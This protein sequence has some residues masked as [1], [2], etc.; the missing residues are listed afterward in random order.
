M[1]SQGPTTLKPIR[2]ETWVSRESDDLMEQRHQLGAAL[3]TFRQATALSQAQVGTNTGY[4]RTSI[5]KI[6]RG[7]R[8][9]LTAC[10][11]LDGWCHLRHRLLLARIW[12][13]RP[14][15]QSFP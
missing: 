15:S 14:R 10:V 13:P 12:Q 4:D 1:G 3:A 6:E 11:G 5:N 8:P 7:T 9:M 2:E